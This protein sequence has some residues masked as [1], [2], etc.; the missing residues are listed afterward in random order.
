AE[1]GTMWI[2][3]QLARIR[4]ANRMFDVAL[5]QDMAPLQAFE[6]ATTEYQSLNCTCWQWVMNP[7]ATQ[8]QTQ[9]M[10]EFLLSAGYVARVTDILHLDQIPPWPQ[11]RTAEQLTI[12]PAR[13]S[14]RHAR[15]LHEQRTAAL[16]SEPQLAD[17]AMLHLDDPHYDALLALKQGTAVA[18]VGVLAMGEIGV[19]QEL[20]VAP[21]FREQHIGTSMMWRALEICGRSLFRHVFAG[22]DPD[23]A[24]AQHLLAKLGFR[25][26]GQFIA[27]EKPG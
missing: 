19:I 27:Y 12:I 26:V 25:R 13:A 24:I 18:H 2:N 11:A 21:A 20:Y 7:S 4:Q 3:P 23:D 6:A 17:A 14:F 15:I 5:P 1:F 16:C 22:V 8:Q 10:I 9:P